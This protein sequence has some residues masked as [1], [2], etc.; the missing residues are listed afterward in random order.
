MTTNQ[1]L[2]DAL[3]E[4]AA[5]LAQAVTADELLT[6]AKVAALCAQAE[7]LVSAENRK[8]ILERALQKADTL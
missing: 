3:R 6:L 8:S 7:D 2:I 4:R 5:Q 1:A